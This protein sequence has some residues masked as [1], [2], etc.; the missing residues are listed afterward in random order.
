MNIGQLLT[1]I[2]ARHATAFELVGRL[3]GG[4]QDGA[5]TLAEP[6]GRRAVLKQLFADRALPI[7][8]RLRAIGYPTPDVLYTGTADDG[9]A[10]L[11]QEFV[12]GAPMQNLTE[13]YLDQLFA[14]NDRQADLNPHPEAS[15]L[16]SWS[17]YVQEVVFARSSVWVRALRS[18]S[19]ASASLLSALQQATQPYA[20]TV[21]A[22]SDVV[23]GDLHNGNILV[24]HGQITGVIDMVYAGYGTRAI[25]LATLLHT[26]DSDDYAPIIRQRLRA[27]VIERFGPAVYAI[28]MAYRAIVTLEWAI[29]HDRPDLIDYFIR[30]GWATCADLQGLRTED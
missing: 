26:I 3:P 8:R 28:C 27:H 21:L 29:R 11:V 22:N 30:A 9:T 5:Y 17:G 14:L 12:P 23:H 2:N 4:H 10:Y 24:E 18:H 13:A 16:E 25:D 7:M 1:Y 20:A 15:A 6:G 19:P